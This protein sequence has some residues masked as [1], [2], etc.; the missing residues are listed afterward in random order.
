MAI[1]VALPWRAIA[2]DETVE[3]VLARHLT[4]KGGATWE[5]LE[6]IE[7]TGSYTAYSVVKPFRLV[8][9][10]P[11]RYF[12][13]RFENQHTVV[14][15]FDGDVSWWI[16]P[17]YGIEHPFRMGGFDARYLK[18][19][20]DFDCVLIHPD[21]RGI[22]VELVGIEDL[23]GSPAIGLR[24]T[25]PDGAVTTVYL[26]PETYLERA[27]MGTTGTWGFEAPSETWFDDYREEDGVTIA[28]YQERI[29]GDD[30]SIIEIDSVETDIELGEGFFAMPPPEGMMPL[31]AMVGEWSV[32]VEQRPFRPDDPWLESAGTATFAAVQ[33]GGLLSERLAYE[34]ADGTPVVVIRQWTHD[35]FAERYRVTSHNDFNSQ[36]KVLEGEMGEGGLVLD[37]LR[38]GTTEIDG[39]GGAAHRR[40]TVTGFDSEEILVV[41]E[42]SSDDG[43][44]WEPLRRYTYKRLD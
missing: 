21:K 19:R 3:D 16:N 25:R 5:A 6:T 11:N 37:T 44:T 12:F 20:A 41:I 10:R 29:A 22:S 23:E 18:H 33:G 35:R 1:L 34:G 36:M 39:G 8:R 30:Y 38:T 15:A 24:A 26:D 31:Q 2:A 7:I 27:V 40:I 28:F 14:T 4:A 43:A 9:Q 13:D 32:K 17:F 42:T